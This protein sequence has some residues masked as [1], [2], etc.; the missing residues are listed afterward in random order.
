VRSA[1]DDVAYDLMARDEWIFSRRQVPFH[2]VKVGAA[3]AAGANPKKHLT[4]PWFGL[5]NFFN[6]KRLARASEDGG[7]QGLANRCLDVFADSRTG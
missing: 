1:V 7:F 2:N 5:R 6:L 3:H 4:G